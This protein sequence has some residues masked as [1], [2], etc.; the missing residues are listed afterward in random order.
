[1][2][3]LFKGVIFRFYVS[4]P[5]CN[6]ERIEFAAAAMI[7]VVTNLFKVHESSICK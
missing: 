1:M 5:G 7:Y 3:F 2:I 4:F 6:P